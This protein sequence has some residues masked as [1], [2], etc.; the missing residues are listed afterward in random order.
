MQF[1][2]L[3]VKML[4]WEILAVGVVV[5]LIVRYFMRIRKNA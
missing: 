2:F 3:E 1:H 5:V 4:W